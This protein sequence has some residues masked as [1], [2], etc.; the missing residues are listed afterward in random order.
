MGARRSDGIDWAATRER[1]VRRLRSYLRGLPPATI[2]D[3]A[4]EVLMGLHVSIASRGLPEDLE[5]LVTV[6]SRRKAASTLRQIIL[7]RVRAGAGLTIERF[8]DPEFEVDLELIR[9]ERALLAHRLLARMREHRAQ[10]AVIA[11]GRMRGEGFEVIALAL[12]QSATTL[13]Q[14]W[15]RC[16]AR[17]QQAIRRGEIDER[18]L[19]VERGSRP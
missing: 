5:A 16:L 7:Q 15:H 18:G 8:A 19:D 6:I 12:G 1:V 11:E 3:T 13:R 4:Q 17:I 9:E 2:E 14:R 10:C